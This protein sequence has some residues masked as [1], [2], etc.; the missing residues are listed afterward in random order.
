MHRGGCALLI[1]N[2][3]AKHIARIETPSTE[4]IFLKLKCLPNV[5]FAAC[6]LPPSDSPYHTWAP[7]SE[8]QEQMEREPDAQFVIMGDLNAR[9]GDNRTAFLEDKGI[10]NASYYKSPDTIASPN[11][12]A[13]YILNTLGPKTV[14]LN[15]LKYKN[16][17]CPTNLT[18]RQK[19]KWISE[20]D[21]CL[22]SPKCLI[23][24]SDFHIHQEKDLPSDHAP[25]SLILTRDDPDHTE[26]TDLELT[27]ERASS[28][29]QH[30]TPNTQTHSVIDLRR[31]PLR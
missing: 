7:I 20:L 1:R 18:F 17:S 9:F 5:I 4:C 11:Q 3:I 15:G 12:N 28:L 27:I 19:K 16:I 31:K 8:I 13:R 25:I 23:M 26:L 30:E 29:G 6:Y 21:V 22:L 14:L 2:C 10:D 24:V